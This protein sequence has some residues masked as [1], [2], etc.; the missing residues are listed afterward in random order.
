MITLEM[1]DQV[2][3]RT[4][5]TY[6]EA[7]KAL[8]ENGEDVI[9]AIIAI[10]SNTGKFGEKF[11]EDVNLKKE[12]LIMTLKDILNKGNATKIV[13]EKNGEVYLSIPM[14]VAIPVGAITIFNPILIAV[15]GV[16]GVGAYVG[17]F[18][19]KVIKSDGTEVNVNEETE[20]RIKKAKFERNV[21][22]N[23]NKMK[24]GIDDVADEIIDI[25]DQVS[26]SASEV[27]KDVEDAIDEVK[28]EFKNE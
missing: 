20:K 17:N 19:V 8:E 27:K 7:K 18:T 4:G 22:R 28:D 14:T 6:A 10:E 21:K 15:L 25:T 23:A 12:D 2:V 16:L 26:E 24:D 13:V 9:S 1:I 11:K 3:E 5:I